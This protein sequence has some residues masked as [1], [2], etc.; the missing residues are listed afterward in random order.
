MHYDWHTLMKLVAGHGFEPCLLAYETRE[1]AGNLPPAIKKLKWSGW[2]DS[3]SRF[4]PSKGDGSTRL[5]YT[6]ITYKIIFNCKKY[7]YHKNKNSQDFSVFR[8]KSNSF[9]INFG[10]FVITTHISINL[11]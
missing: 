8:S 9:L 7:I 11:R 4:P 1:I 3:N 6:P 10:T 5:A 2:R